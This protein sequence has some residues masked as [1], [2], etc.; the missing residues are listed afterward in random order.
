MTISRQPLELN[1]P[2]LAVTFPAS[3][4]TSM[5]GGFVN[6]PLDGVNLQASLPTFALGY[7]LV[8]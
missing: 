1:Q 7:E 5:F 3:L 6:E 8:N 2:R 4:Q